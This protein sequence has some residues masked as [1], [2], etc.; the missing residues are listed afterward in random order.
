MKSRFNWDIFYRA[1][2]CRKRS[3]P[4]IILKFLQKHVKILMISSRKPLQLLVIHRNIANEFVKYSKKLHNY[5][6]TS[7]IFM[8]M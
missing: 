5:L 7:S 3:K 6:L 1:K 8:M 4:Q 2:N